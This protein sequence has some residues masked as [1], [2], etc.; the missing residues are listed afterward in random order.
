MLSPRF[1]E[2]L[3]TIWVRPS[4]RLLKHSSLSSARC[5]SP[6]TFSS[7]L[8]HHHRRMY[9]RDVWAK[10]KHRWL[11]DHIYCC[12]L[13]YSGNILQRRTVPHLVRTLRVLSEQDEDATVNR[14]RSSSTVS[15]VRRT[16]PD[17][18]YR[19]IFWAGFRRLRIHGRVFNLN[20][21]S[22]I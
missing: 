4:E 20:N 18:V 13:L 21:Q 10:S 15:L 8:H 1:S 22:I 17:R 2:S 3:D 6:R 11:V 16:N 12:I 9:D 14:I 7:D 19:T 5:S